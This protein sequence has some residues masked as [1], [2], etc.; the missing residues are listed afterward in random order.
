M[1]PHPFI[2]LPFFCCIEIVEALLANG[3]DTA[4]KNNAGSTSM[5][6]VTVPFEDVKGIYDYF[7]KT[8]GP[9]GLKLDYGQIKTTR[10][11]IAEMLRN[12]TSE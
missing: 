5:E 8:L 11:I 2:L 6:S 3:C 10:P 9:L 7:R 12:N 1:D 4:I